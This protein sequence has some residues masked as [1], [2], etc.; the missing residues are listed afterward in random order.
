MSSC[1]HR[2]I[3]TY[4]FAS[5]ILPPTPTPGFGVCR[6][7]CSASRDI[8]RKALCADKTACLSRK[9]QFYSRTAPFSSKPTVAAFLTWE[10]SLLEGLIQCF[11]LNTT[12]RRHVS[13]LVRCRFFAPHRQYPVTCAPLS[14]SLISFNLSSTPELR[15]R[16]LHP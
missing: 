15:N 1:T 10:P 8:A 2:D 6:T 14:S 9:P 4:S 5:T 11:L 3:H 16:I 13:S 7:R 12:R